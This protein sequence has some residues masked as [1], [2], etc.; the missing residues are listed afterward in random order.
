[1]HEH[2]PDEIDKMRRMSLLVWVDSCQGVSL[3]FLDLREI[4]NN[5]EQE[6][7]VC[8]VRRCKIRVAD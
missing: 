1:M 6:N 2:I 3:V 8:H 5:A 4:R 7:S